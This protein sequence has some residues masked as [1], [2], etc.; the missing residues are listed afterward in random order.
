MSKP[1]IYIARFVMEAETPLFVGS[2]KSSPLKDAL[3]QRDANGFPMIPGTALAG[4]L[5]H[6]LAEESVTLANRLFGSGKKRRKEETKKNHYKEEIEDTGQ[7]S[8]VKLSPG[9]LFLGENKVSEGLILDDKF[10]EVKIIFDRLPVRQH[11]ALNEKGTAKKGQLYDHEVIFQG[12][13]FVFELEAPC[14]LVSEENWKKLMHK[15]KSGNFRLGAGTRNGYGLLKVV[16]CYEQRISIQEYLDLSPSLNES[17]WWKYLAKAALES[18]PKGLITYILEIQP[19]PFFIFGSGLSDL[20]VDQTPVSEKVISYEG[21]V[22]RL[23]DAPYTLVPASSVKGAIAHRVAY[24]YNKDEEVKRFATLAEIERIRELENEAVSALF[25][26]AGQRVSDPTAGNVFFKDVF[27]KPAKVNNEEIFNHVAIDRFTG[28]AMDGMLFSEK[29]SHFTES[30]DTLVLKV[31]LKLTEITKPHQA[32][33]ENALKDICRGL[34][35]LGGMTTK[36]HGIFTGTLK[37][38]NEVIFN[39]S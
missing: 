1:H 37:K 21:G 8:P 11:A 31:Q 12:V 35:P 24:Y 29:V 30:K 28:G 13:R 27:L 9:F 22:L 34:L 33:L 2:G 4:V 18:S 38:D 14:H 26:N 15:V 25:G 6:A 16:G 20:D 36:G 39:Y 7:G 23:S 10:A 19:D 5:R 17:R 3:V 32:H